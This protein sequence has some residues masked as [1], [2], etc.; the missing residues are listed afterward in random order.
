MTLCLAVVFTGPAAGQS[1]CPVTEYA[2]YKDRAVTPDG[3]RQLATDACLYRRI[4][5]IERRHM[6]KSPT[7]T[8]CSAEVTKITDALT[9]SRDEQQLARVRAN[10]PDMAP[11]K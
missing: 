2:Q 5:D 1:L 6:V 4:Y 3:R 11:P 10:C 8:T 9:A 7:L